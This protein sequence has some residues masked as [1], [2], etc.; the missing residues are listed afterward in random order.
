M[1]APV[2]A[3][4]SALHVRMLGPLEIH[5]DGRLLGD[6]AWRSARPRELFLHLVLHPEGRTR[7]QIGLVF[8]PDASAAQLRNNFHVTLHHV[9]K[10]LGRADAVVVERERYRLDPALGAWCDALAFPRDML[11]ALRLARGTTDARPALEAALALYRGDLCEGLDVGDWHL[12]AHDHLRRL[13]TDGCRALAEAHRAAGDDAAAIGVLER[14]L[15]LDDLHEGAARMLLEAYVR[16]GQR[17]RAVALYR[18]FAERL[19]RELDAEPEPVTTALYRR[20]V[21]PSA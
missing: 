1:P 14:L 13:A 3:R 2:V 12:E 7:E 11:D 16:T 6:D 18:D 10:A 8:W 9:R 5:V 19:R 4:R 21:T 17:G 15:H 20:I